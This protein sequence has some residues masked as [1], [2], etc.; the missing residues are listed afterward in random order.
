MSV[1]ILNLHGTD[2]YASHKLQVDCRYDE[3]L[4]YFNYRYCRPLP[5]R[6]PACPPRFHDD[7][8][9]ALNSTK[10]DGIASSILVV[11]L[12]MMYWRIDG[13]SVHR[14]ETGGTR[15]GRI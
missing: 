7:G 1:A 8:L 13:V 3:R 2:K 9:S 14:Y 10:D 12:Q 11:Q 6:P 5:H 4:S 15:N